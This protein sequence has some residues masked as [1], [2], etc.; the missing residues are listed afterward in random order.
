[1]INLKPFANKI[2]GWVY[3]KFPEFFSITKEFLPKA[4]IRIPTRT[5][6]SLGLLYASIAYILSL[7]MI[8][9]ALNL[10]FNLFLFLKIAFLIFLP[11]FI[12][13]IVFLIYIYAPSFKA[14][15]RKREIE[16]IYP[17]V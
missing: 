14:Q 4:N 11:F 10:F 12:S 13:I 8:S 3:D 5:Y 17:L 16:R 7:F 6:V 1:M 2:F 15:D 9:V